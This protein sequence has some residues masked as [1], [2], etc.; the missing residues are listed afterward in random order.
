MWKLSTVVVD[1]SSLFNFYWFVF[2]LTW[3]TV[4]TVSVQLAMCRKASWGLIYPSPIIHTVNISKLHIHKLDSPQNAARFSFHG[5]RSTLSSC[6][7]CQDFHGSPPICLTRPRIS[8]TSA[9]PGRCSDAVQ[10]A[11][12]AETQQN[13]TQTGDSGVS[14]DTSDF[15]WHSV[16][17]SRGMSLWVNVSPW[18]TSTLW[19]GWKELSSVVLNLDNCLAS[20]SAII[21][22]QLLTYILATPTDQLIIFITFEHICSHSSQPRKET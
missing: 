22:H 13:Q 16:V 17:K 19:N 4:S 15:L 18:L 1:I 2:G 7:C 20:D 9:G 12:G 8:W 5:C 6:H 11:E 14:K 21:E 3:C 10:S